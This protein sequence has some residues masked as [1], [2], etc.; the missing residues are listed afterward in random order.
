TVR[1]ATLQ[2]LATCPVVKI[3]LI[4]GSP[5]GMSMPLRRV[6]QALQIFTPTRWPALLA[7]WVHDLQEPPWCILGR[8]RSQGLWV[9]CRAHDADGSRLP[10]SG[11]VRRKSVRHE[12]AAGAVP[13]GRF[14][15]RAN[16]RREAG[17][18]DCA[19]Q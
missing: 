3:V 4:A 5:I 11:W 10:S 2:I 15:K 19:M 6:R 14:V 7:C 12:P 17:S 16:G 8:G 13:D 9:E 1:G 18:Q